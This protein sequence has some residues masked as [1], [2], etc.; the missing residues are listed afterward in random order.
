MPP[1]ANAVLDRV[2]GPATSISSSRSVD[3]LRLSDTRSFLRCARV[4]GGS[5]KAARVARVRV[6]SKPVWPQITR[7][8][9]TFPNLAWLEAGAVEALAPD[10][11]QDVGLGR[12]PPAKP[13]LRGRE[14]GLA[15]A[16]SPRPGADLAC[17]PSTIAMSRSSFS[18][19]AFFPFPALRTSSPCSCGA[20]LP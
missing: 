12:H 20:T 4:H 3:R 5:C 9:G 14:L 1:P 15:P 19:L 17:I 6:P 16:S 2:E 10:C 11:L 18:S 8:D 7:G 13:N